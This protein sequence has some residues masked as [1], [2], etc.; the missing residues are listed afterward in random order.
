MLPAAEFNQFTQSQT[1]FQISK[2]CQS[3]RLREKFLF[4]L[5]SDL[6][7][8]TGKAVILA[9]FPQFSSRVV[10]ANPVGLIL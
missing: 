5:K 3:L 8:V 9:N 1:S 6:L 2:L 4:I 7:A 10:S